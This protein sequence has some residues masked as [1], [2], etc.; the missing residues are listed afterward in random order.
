M[1]VPP[2][3]GTPGTLLTGGWAHLCCKGRNPQ[4]V[5][6]WN[7]PFWGIRPPSELHTCEQG[8]QP[9][10]HR[11]NGAGPGG[12]C[13]Q[14]LGEAGFPGRNVQNVGWTPGCSPQ[15]APGPPS[16]YGLQFPPS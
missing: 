15:S 8:T 2:S 12:P 9:R 1:G 14:T 5:E 4:A 6:L 3:P 7:M 11:V 13:D 10:V 16:S